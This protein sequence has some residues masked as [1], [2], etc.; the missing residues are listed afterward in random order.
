M[1]RAG[2]KKQDATRSGSGSEHVIRCTYVVW[3]GHT[4][5]VWQPMLL[6]RWRG[7]RWHAD[8]ADASGG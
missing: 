7:L 1:K 2:E 4:V 5:G 8:S 6:R 3:R